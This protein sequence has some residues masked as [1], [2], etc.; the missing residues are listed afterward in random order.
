[1]AGGM[2]MRTL[3]AIFFLAVSVQAQTFGPTV[4]RHNVSVGSYSALTGISIT[5]T[6]GGTITSGSY[7]ATYRVSG[8]NRFGRIPISTNLT[9]T[10][11]GSTNPNAIKLNMPQY[12]GIAAYVVEKSWDSGTNWT[13]WIAF[14][15][16]GTNFTDYGTN[17]WTA[18]N[19]SNTFAIIAA[20]TVDLSGAASVIG[21]GAATNSTHLAGVAAADY[22]VKSGT[23]ADS[24]LP[25]VYQLDGGATGTAPLVVESG[26]GTAY[27]SVRALDTNAAGA[28]GFVLGLRPT[29]ATDYALW[30]S[31]GVLSL[32]YGL[33]N[34]T[35]PLGAPLFTWTTNRTVATQPLEVQGAVLATNTG[36]TSTFWR[37]DIK[38]SGET[39]VVASLTTTGGQWDI[40]AHVDGTFSIRNGTN[41]VLSFS[42]GRTR[43]RGAPLT[44]NDTNFFATFPSNSSLYG[45]LVV[46]GG[47]PRVIPYGANQTVPLSSATNASAGAGIPTVTVTNFGLEQLTNVSFVEFGKSNT[48]VLIANTN[49]T[50]V[51][52]SPTNLVTHIGANVLAYILVNDGPGSGI[53]ADLGDGYDFATDFQLTAGMTN[54]FQKTGDTGGSLRVNRKLS[55]GEI[56]LSATAGTYNSTFAM[57]GAFTGYVALSI[58]RNDNSPLLSNSTIYIMGSSN[59]VAEDMVRHTTNR[60]SLS[61]VGDDQILVVTTIQAGVSSG[62]FVVNVPYNTTNHLYTYIRWFD[63]NISPVLGNI[64]WGTS[65]AQA[66]ASQVQFDDGGQLKVQQQNNFASEVETLRLTRDFL[67]LTAID[68]IRII[69]NDA[70]TIGCQS[71]AISSGV[72]SASFH[73]PRCIGVKTNQNPTIVSVTGL[74]AGDYYIDAGSNTTVELGQDGSTNSWRWKLRN[75]F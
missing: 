32:R 69:A 51:G 10:F 73:V 7:I 72:T 43:M 23:L 1:M 20:P 36:T 75:A 55:G 5:L 3:F 53:N 18:G 27:P 63:T 8:T 9:V 6:N 67:E 2:N 49:G 24:N 64:Y 54:Y 46:E 39:Q 12:N 71:F 60:M 66:V 25:T 21:T 13:N 38:A 40:S 17:T 47:V 14:S 22:F 62:T 68:D 26:N 41:D 50:F 19:F 58:L 61:V 11:T 34:L 15:A 29:N 52:Q 28:A 45:W 16:S 37:V 74:R 59:N 42:G 44:L 33:D 65:L 30:N 57:N 4:F 48:W 70:I 56:S 31:N 35:A